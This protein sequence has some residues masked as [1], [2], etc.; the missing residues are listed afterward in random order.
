MNFQ[1][2]SD[3]LCDTILGINWQGESAE[4]CG[5]AQHRTSGAVQEDER[6]LHSFQL[7]WEKGCCPV[8]IKLHMSVI[9]RSRQS[10]LSEPQR[11][12][13]LRFVFSPRPGA[14]RLAVPGG[15][16]LLSCFG[17]MPVCQGARAL[18][19]ARCCWLLDATVFTKTLP[20]KRRLE[21]ECYLARLM[22][23]KVFFLGLARLLHSLGCL[24]ICCL[25][26][27]GRVM[28]L[29]KQKNIKSTCWNSLQYIPKNTLN[30]LIAS[31]TIK[32][33]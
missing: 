10:L 7:V 31:Y 24:V 30:T 29:A 2:L 18:A 28:S 33:V 13:T 3:S 26:H 6:E 19:R 1:H 9:I 32:M 22:V 8:L 20:R 16:I 21:T 12:S 14:H 17:L 11:I 4:A 25:N 27:G 15:F 5:T 23:L